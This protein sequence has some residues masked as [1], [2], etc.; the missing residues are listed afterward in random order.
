MD[1]GA[2]ISLLLPSVRSQPDYFVGGQTGLSLTGVDPL[3]V[4]FGI[5]GNGVDKVT[6][7]TSDNGFQ[8]HCSTSRDPSITSID[9]Y[10]G[11]GT[12]VGL[13]NANFREGYYAD[14]R[15]SVLQI[16]LNRRLSFCDAGN[17]S[18]VVETNS[19]QTASRSFHLFIGSKQNKY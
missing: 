16:G 13:R 9:W 18:C 17:Y 12:K 8:M 5:Y 10:F 19:S 3:I 7:Q 1:Q 14:N 4:E 15:T 2:A 11:N 6:R